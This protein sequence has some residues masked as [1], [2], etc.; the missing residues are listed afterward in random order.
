MTNYTIFAC[1]QAYLS[2]LIEYVERVSFFS[3]G[4]SGYTVARLWGHMPV[5]PLAEPSLRTPALVLS[6]QIFVSVDVV[7][8]APHPCGHRLVALYEYLLNCLLVLHGVTLDLID[9]SSYISSTS[10]IRHV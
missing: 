8:V 1:K 6:L 2:Y 3:P 9:T 5:W 7:E 4:N 10:C